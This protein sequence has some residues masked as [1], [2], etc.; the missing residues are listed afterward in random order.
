MRFKSG[1][2]LR[3]WSSSGIC[4]RLW[5]RRLVAFDIGLL[6]W[7]TVLVCGVGL[8]PVPIYSIGRRESI[9]CGLLGA[10]LE[11]KS[12]R[13]KGTSNSYPEEFSIKHELKGGEMVKLTE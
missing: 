2:S 9:R 7:D 10:T 11:L 13:F 8:Y 4:L 1:I 6:G 12:E 3:L 5:C